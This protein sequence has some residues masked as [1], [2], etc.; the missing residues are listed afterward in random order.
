MT[1]SAPQGEMGELTGRAGQL[2]LTSG[3]RRRAAKK[4]LRCSQLE[5]DGNKLVA[6]PA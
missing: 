4:L 3:A 5:G 1:R 6:P 2:E